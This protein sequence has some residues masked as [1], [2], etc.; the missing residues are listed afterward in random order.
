MLNNAATV[1]LIPVMFTHVVNAEEAAQ[2][3]TQPTYQDIETI[4]VSGSRYSLM[5]AQAGSN[6]SLSKD[7]ITKMP[8]LADDVFR[9]MPS[10][11]GVSAGDFSAS[12]NVRGGEAD[13]VLVLLDGQQLYR[14][15]HMKSFSS[16]FSIIDSENIGQMD[17]SSGG[18]SAQYGNKMSGVLNLTSLEPSDETQYSMGVSFI[19]AR[20]SSQGSFDNG[21][22]SWLVSARR[23]YLDII[24]KALEDESGTFEPVY[25]DMYS[26]ISYQLTDDHELVASLLYAYD[27]EVLDDT[28]E[29]DNGTIIKE[30][31]SGKYA[32]SYLWFGLNSQWSDNLNANTIAS[33][34]RVEEDR[35]GGEDDPY[36]VFVRVKDTKS[37]NFI[38]LKQDWHYRLSDEQ[39]LTWGFDIKS[40]EAEYDYKSKALFV[41]GYEGD[42]F[43][44]RESIIETK[45]NEYGLYVNDKIRLAQ[46]WVAEIGVRW[47]KQTYLGFNDDQFSPRA[48]LAYSLSETSTLRFSWGHYFQAQD[49]LSLQVSDGVTDFSPAQKAEHFIIGFDTQ[50]SDSLSIRAEVY[51]KLLTEIQPRFES[52]LD[53]FDSFPEGQA[54]RVKISPDSADITGVELSFKQRISGPLSWSGNYTWSKATDVINGEDFARSWD[55]RHAVNLSVNYAFDNGWNLHAAYVYHS[56]WPIT[57]E[58]GT[59]EMTPDGEY[60]ITQ[61]LAKRN[62]EQLG[63]YNRI[64]FRASKTQQLS[65]STLTWFVEITNLLGTENECCIDNTDYYVDQNG[66]VIANQ[67]KGYWLPMIPSLGVSWQF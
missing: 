42:D 64:D 28:F 29:D 20:A 57:D 55:Q 9:M 47:D 18:F 8:H 59:A 49:I 12:F 27:D 2:K 32:S 60:E 58:Y 66:D 7:E 13:E 1:M 11:P 40:L 56:G 31:I 36:E 37:F 25:A 51:Q 34:G 3:S 67:E 45:G 21:K 43:I 52:S 19:N 39:V 17:F 48:S 33:V 63:S 44:A 53:R 4:V 15:F 62:D 61:H 41:E 35:R 14:P 16:A 6:M 38:G 50:W 65:N 30:K 5:T 22:G 26:K 24:L 54:D 46:R 10:L 23:G